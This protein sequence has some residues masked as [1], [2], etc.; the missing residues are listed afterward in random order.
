MLRSEAERWKSVKH[1]TCETEEQHFIMRA[2]GEKLQSFS[3]DSAGNIDL[4]DGVIKE[5][6][7]AAMK[8]LFRRT[9][10]ENANENL[11]FLI[12]NFISVFRRFMAQ[13]LHNSFAII[14][15]RRG[16]C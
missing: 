10:R 13:F 16:L 2:F 5:L 11:S 3:E 6:I 7:C 15:T 12:A 9:E 8:L 14:S 1:L 4:S